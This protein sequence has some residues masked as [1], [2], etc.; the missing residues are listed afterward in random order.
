[1]RFPAEIY[2]KMKDGH[3]VGL[4]QDDEEDYE[5]FYYW[6][7]NEAL[8][9][10]FLCWEETNDWDVRLMLD[11]LYLEQLELISWFEANHLAEKYIPEI[12][13]QLNTMNLED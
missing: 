12:L 1:M 7:L 11:A 3:V 13:E 4:I 8:T 5:R 6:N 9:A 2:L 10:R